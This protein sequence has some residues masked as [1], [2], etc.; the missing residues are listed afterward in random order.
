MMRS[1]GSLRLLLAAFA[2]GHLLPAQA[3][4]QNDEMSDD[5]AGMEQLRKR[6]MLLESSMPSWMDSAEVQGLV[7]GGIRNGEFMGAMGWGVRDATLQKPVTINTVFSA[8]SLT[9][10][11]VA[12]LVLQLVDEGLLGLDQPLAEIVALPEL[13]DDPRAATITIRMILSHSS[14]LPNWR[15]DAPL[16]LGFDPGSRFQYS[17]EGYVWLARVIEERTGESLEELVLQKVFIPLGMKSSSLIWEERF[18]EDIA[19]GHRDNGEPVELQMDTEPNA[20]AS[21]LTTAGDYCLFVAAALNGTQLSEWIHGQWFESQVEVADGVSWGLGWGIQEKDGRRSLWHWGDNT[22]YKAFVTADLT[23]R[24]GAIVLTNSDHG[25]AMMNEV[26]NTIT[27]DS[28]PGLDWLGYES[29]NSPGRVVRRILERVLNQEGAQATIAE[30]ESLK[31]R[32]PEE[33]FQ[34]GLLN[35]LGYS[36]LSG[37]HLDDAIA[38]FE[39]NVAEY[40]GSFNPYDSLGE[41]Y[42]VQGDIERAIVNYERS[43]E[44]NPE[45]T[46]GVTQLKEL[47]KKLPE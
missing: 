46:N 15:R 9:K 44:L 22:G 18:A 10:P 20:A 32:Y 25:M 40:P 47:R 34:E 12:Y 30:Y 26:F 14:G 31:R 2:V 6:I 16:A 11:V 13:D 3:L 39:L 33:A 7:L 24:M 1:H 41:A 36:V 19:I 8:A 37:D 45:N 4:A 17:G 28:Q 35:N 38:L 29:F 5:M 27:G 42:M 23:S 43:V 21:L